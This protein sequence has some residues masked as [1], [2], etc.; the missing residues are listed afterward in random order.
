MTFQQQDKLKAKV[1]DLRTKGCRLSIQ[2]HANKTV[3]I[4]DHIR[5]QSETF[6]SFRDANDFLSDSLESAK[7]EVE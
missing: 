1:E 3:R 4:D 5:Q 2:I 7:A 6:G